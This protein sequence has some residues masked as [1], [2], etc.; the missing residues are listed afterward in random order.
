MKGIKPN[1]QPMRN[2][3]IEKIHVKEKQSHAQDN[4]YMVR[5]F[6]YIHGVAG[7]S[8]LS[9]KPKSIGPS[10]SAHGLSLSKSPIKK[11]PRN[12]IRVWSSNR[13]KQNLA[14]Q[15]PIN[16]PLGDQLNYQHQTTIL[17]ETILHPYNSSSC[18][19]TRRP[20]EVVHNFNFSIVTP[21]VNMSAQFLDP[22]IFSSITSL[23][24]T[25]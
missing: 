3:K 24:S 11:K 22:Q 19:Q 12:I 1:S 17:Q 20:I 25:R 21:L 15:S 8:L 9:G 13:I 10:R 14:P 23:S 18:P 6:T 7:I 5:Q 2:K 16:L 4:I